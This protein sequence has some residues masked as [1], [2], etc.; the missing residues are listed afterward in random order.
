MK[1]RA[2]LIKHALKSFQFWKLSK[3]GLC[4]K[5]YSIYLQT[6]VFFLVKWIEDWPYPFM[7]EQKKWVLFHAVSNT[8]ILQL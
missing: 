8:A 6:M 5:R 2:F 3:Q 1:I 4:T 7:L